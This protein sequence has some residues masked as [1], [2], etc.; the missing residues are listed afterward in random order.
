MQEMVRGLNKDRI[1]IHKDQFIKANQDRN[2]AEAVRIGELV[3]SEHPNSRLALEI[4]D[5]IDTLRERAG[6]GP[7][8]QPA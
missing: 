5:V 1:N 7:Q 3:I 6:T 8:L 2:Y 4:R